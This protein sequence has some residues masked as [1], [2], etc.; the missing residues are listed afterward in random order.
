MVFQCRFRCQFSA[1]G[2]QP[3]GFH[4]QV[5]DC[6]ACRPSG[7]KALPANLHNRSTRSR[8]FRCGRR[9]FMPRRDSHAGRDT[10]PRKPAP[11]LNSV[12]R[13]CAGGNFGWCTRARLPTCSGPDDS[14]L[15]RE[16][17]GAHSG[18]RSTFASTDHTSGGGAAMS[19]VILNW[20]RII[21]SRQLLLALCRIAGAKSDKPI[22]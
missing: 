2:L 14:F 6:S 21:A 7:P 17:L 11:G 1:T 10:H 8:N 12:T 18:H 3:I 19:T 20:V 16:M 9:Y 4:R 15:T 22:S 5:I 13:Q